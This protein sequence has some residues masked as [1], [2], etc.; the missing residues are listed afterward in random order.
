MAKKTEPPVK[1]RYP[2]CHML[3]DSTAMDKKDAVMYGK[4]NSYYHPDCL[5][6]MLTVTAIRDKFIRE[7]NPLLTGQQ[8]GLLVSTINNLIFDKGV[9]VDYIEFALDYMIKYKQGKLK[10]PQGLHYIVQDHDIEAAWKKKQEAMVKK[11]MAEKLKAEHGA[12]DESGGRTF[13]YKRS[14]PVGFQ[15][16]LK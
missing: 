10:H 11:E 3:H 7:I 5:H 13:V 9:D 6:T 2:K 8:I 12:P 16:I 1:C 15:D 14:E 4:S